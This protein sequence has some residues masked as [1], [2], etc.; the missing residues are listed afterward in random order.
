MDSFTGA[1]LEVV[2][3]SVRFVDI[4]LHGKPYRI[5]CYLCWCVPHARPEGTWW[6]PAAANLAPEGWTLSM[7]HDTALSLAC[8]GAERKGM[9]WRYRFK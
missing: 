9:E 7:M 4:R 6:M 5:N 8:P 2:K 1:A 3:R